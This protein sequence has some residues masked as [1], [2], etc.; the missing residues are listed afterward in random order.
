MNNDKYETRASKNKFTAEHNKQISDTIES[1]KWISWT[2]RPRSFYR[3]TESSYNLFIDTHSAAFFS[4]SSSYSATDR[5]T[6]YQLHAGDLPREPFDT[7]N[8]SYFL[9]LHNKCING[10]W[11]HHQPK[12]ERTTKIVYVSIIMRREGGGGSFS[13]LTWRMEMQLSECL[14]HWMPAQPATLDNWPLHLIYSSSSSCG[15]FIW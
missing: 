7:T 10:L 9:L 14:F 12:N 4:T 5:P 1:A 15:Y 11:L 3:T 2:G 13:V 6:I 8:R